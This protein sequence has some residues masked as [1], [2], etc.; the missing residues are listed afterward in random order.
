MSTVYRWSPIDEFAPGVL[1]I[2]C[3]NCEADLALHQP[4]PELVGRL[5]ATC[6]ECKSWFLANSEGNVL[7][8]VPRFPD[9][10]APL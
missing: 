4:D 8:R 7:I 1:A 9:D 6:D 5:L 10:S 2:S 3:P